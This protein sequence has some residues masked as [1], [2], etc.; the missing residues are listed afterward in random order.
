MWSWCGSLADGQSCSPFPFGKLLLYTIGLMMPFVR[1]W[2]C[3][4]CP[5]LIFG[6]TPWLYSLESIVSFL[7]QYYAT[8]KEKT[9]SWMADTLGKVHSLARG[10]QHLWLDTAKG[11]SSTKRI[12]LF[13][14]WISMFPIV[15]SI[16]FCY[17]YMEIIKHFC[18][19][20]GWSVASMPGNPAVA[21]QG[22]L[23][24]MLGIWG[25]NWAF[26]IIFWWFW[27]GES[28]S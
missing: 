17:N 22:A 16:L 28:I 25:T 11:A 5:T 13:I 6:S 2:S 15:L 26:E 23:K 3:F 1:D 14:P 20:T 18:W 19:S 4:E 7:C 8:L 21:R 10:N 12:M 24:E 9:L 27:F